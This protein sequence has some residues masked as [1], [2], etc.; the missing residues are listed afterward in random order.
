MINDEKLTTLSLDLKSLYH[1]QMNIYALRAAQI[2][3][4][5]FRAF[6]YSKNVSVLI[7]ISSLSDI[8]LLLIKCIYLYLFYLKDLYSFLNINIYRYIYI[9]NFNHNLEACILTKYTTSIQ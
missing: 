5:P 2:C 9:Y 6:S 1:E 7:S 4:R 3:V 8:A